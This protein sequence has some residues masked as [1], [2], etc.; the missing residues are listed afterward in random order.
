[1]TQALP[2]LATSLLPVV[3]FPAAGIMPIHDAAAPYAHEFIFLFMG[4]FM[5]AQAMERWNLHRRVALRVMLVVGTSPVRLVGG[6]MLASAL[7]SMWISNTATAVMMLPVAVSIIRLVEQRV[8]GAG[9]HHRDVEHFS[10]GLLLGV[11]YG[12]SIGGLATLI[13]TPP[14]LF[15]AGFLKTSYGV[16]LGFGRWMLIGLPLTML[17]L[18]ITWL[19]LTGVTFPV[20]LREVPGGQEL[21]RNEAGGLGPLSRGERIVLAVFLAMAL[22]WMA[23]E[24]LAGWAWLVIRL[25]LVTRVS[26]ASIAIAAALL[27]FATPVDRRQGIFALHWETAVRLPWGVLLLFGGGL[28]LAAA[29]RGTG[30][31]TWISGQ[32]TAAAGLP[33]AGL[34]AVVVAMIVFLTELTSN[35]ATAATFLPVL[36]GVASGVSVDPVVLVV[37]AAIAASCAFMMPVATPPNAIVFGSGRVTI[38]QMVR[39]GILLNLISIALI[40][41]FAFAVVVPVMAPIWPGGR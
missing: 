37:P 3:L 1:M 26:D 15:L 28:S 14:N 24:P 27:L 36:S 34:V 10:A 29:V 30:L 18:P 23:R 25:P 16:D 38:G 22:A 12:C 17:L 31:D 40:S 11:A 13:G 39:A 41:L 32:V 20:R 4:G 19:T 5:V 35:T 9:G 21:V 6:A 33:I 8:E 2:L 7:L